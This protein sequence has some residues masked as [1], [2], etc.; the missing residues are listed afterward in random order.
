MREMM[1][2][3]FRML[4][5]PWSS[6][7]DVVWNPSFEVRETDDAFVIKA[8]MPGVRNDDLEI[9]LSGNQ[10]QITGKRDQEQ[11]QDEGRYYTYERSYGSFSRVFVLPDSADVEGIRSELTDGVLTLTVPKKPG[12]SPQRRK[13]QIGSG[14]AGSKS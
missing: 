7:R 14:G 5:A 4:Q 1:I 2:D 11:E 9:S 13:I 12:S 8:D 3:P 6:G 10:L